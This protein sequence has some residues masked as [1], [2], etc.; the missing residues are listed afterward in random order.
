MYL[1]SKLHQSCFKN[2]Y[3]GMTAFIKYAPPKTRND[4]RLIE[5]KKPGLKVSGCPARVSLMF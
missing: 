3:L 2:R 4:R 5:W 1:I